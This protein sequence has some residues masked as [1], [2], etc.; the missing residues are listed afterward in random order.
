MFKIFVILIT[1]IAWNNSAYAYQFSKKEIAI[2]KKSVISLCKAN[3]NSEVEISSQGNI[4]TVL[5]KNLV[6]MDFAG[7]AEFSKTEWKKIKRHL[8]AKINS[9]NHAKCVAEVTP[10]FLDKFSRQYEE[11]TD[12]DM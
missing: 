4:K 6:E 2:V 10:V 9:T 7:A 3:N 1:A 12:V 5:L 8:P 11:E